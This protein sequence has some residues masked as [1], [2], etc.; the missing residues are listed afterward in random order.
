MTR[1][2]AIVATGAAAT[3]AVTGVVATSADATSNSR[4]GGKSVVGAWR[5]TIDPKPNPG[6][7]PPP[8]PTRI[9]FARGGVITEAT[10]SSPPGYTGASTGIGAWKQ[11]KDTVTFTFERFLN[12]DGALAAIQRIQGKATV[13]YTGQSQS[14]PA[15]ATLLSPDGQTVLAS[16]GVHASGTRMTP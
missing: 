13:G 16:F 5:M 2:H 10:S 1:T 4:C 15:T 9:S 3:L 14:G 7:D 6:G 8:F 11:C 12:K